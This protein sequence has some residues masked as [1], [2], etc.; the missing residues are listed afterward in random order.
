MR[1]GNGEGSIFKLGG[2]RRR[3]WA[4]RVTVGFTPEGKQITKYLSYH[5]KK[6]EA[7]KA[8]R[9]YLVS[10][11]DL[12][13][14]DI[15][16]HDVFNEW[17]KVAT[18]TDKTMNN[19]RNIF[20][21]D[22]MFNL[23]KMKIKNIKA[24]HIEEVMKELTPHMQKQLKN[25]LNNLFKHS[26]KNEYINKNIIELINTDS[27]DDV[28]ARIPFT[29]DE[30]EKL[31]Q[32]NH[33]LNDTIFI[34]LYS[35]LRITELLTLKTNDVNLEERYMIGGIKTKA[36]KNRIIP[37]HDEIYDIVKKRYEQGHKYLI[38]RSGQEVIYTSYRK[39]YWNKMCDFLGVNHVPH[40]TRHSFI[41]YAD[42]CELNKVAVKKIVGHT[43]KD[44]MT[45]HY[46]YKSPKDLLNE[47]NKLKY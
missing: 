44:D 1:R 14:K 25:V 24:I 47:I 23:R 11:Y 22:I 28:K 3:P 43:V 15:T 40:E 41:T 2:K 6:S 12:A 4:V 34:L 46:N 13:N 38:S 35:G 7:N 21:R 10:P 29:S 37:I 30:I 8:L 42:K 26:V 18:I 32:F 16:L 17:E 31:K 19:Y 45:E 5:E 39:T 33:P 9:E 36:G 20:T 27:A